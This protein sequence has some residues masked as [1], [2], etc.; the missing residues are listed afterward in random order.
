MNQCCIPIMASPHFIS[1]FQ[2]FIGVRSSKLVLKKKLFT[3]FFEY[4]E[5][6]VLFIKHRHWFELFVFHVIWF[7][8]NVA[9][10]IKGLFQH[11]KRQKQSTV[12]L[13]KRSWKVYSVFLEAL[14]CSL[15]NRDVDTRFELTKAKTN[16]F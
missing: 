10:S 7:R 1:P 15:Y 9:S 3:S 2:L 11:R 13:F 4:W 14:W 5:E 8:E 12:N 16:K 6:L